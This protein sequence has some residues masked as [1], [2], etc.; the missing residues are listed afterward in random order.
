MPKEKK[1]F[2]DT[3]VG[4]FLKEKAPNILNSVGDILPANGAF[5]IVKN[6]ISSD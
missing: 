3:K 2:K 6:L 1:K 5:G 4:V